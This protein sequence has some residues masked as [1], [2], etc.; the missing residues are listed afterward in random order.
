LWETN[1][2]PYELQ[3]LRRSLSD[4]KML[5]QSQNPEVSDGINNAL[6]RYLVVRTCGYLEQ[7]VEQVCL[8]FLNS[9][10]AHP[11]CQSFNGSW[12]GRGRNP[13]PEALVAFVRKFNIALSEELD[14]LFK[15]DDQLLHREISFLVDRRN[16]ISHSLSEGVGVRK[17]LDLVEPACTVAD[18]FINAFD[19]R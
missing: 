14:E 5:V 11:H 17:S 6:A 8:L 16:K 19:P 1:W 15:S 4:L 10:S 9:K 12:F 18:W 3:Q 7:I 2:P 13:N